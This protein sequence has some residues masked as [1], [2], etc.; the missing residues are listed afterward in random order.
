MENLGQFEAFTVQNLKC[1]AS[2]GVQ[3]LGMEDYNHSL[4]FSREKE[5]KRIPHARFYMRTR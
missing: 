5:E 1:F 3:C 4:N 2:D